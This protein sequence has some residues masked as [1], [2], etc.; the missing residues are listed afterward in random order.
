[1]KTPVEKIIEAVEKGYNENS[2]LW[3]EWK[4]T[5]IEAEQEL[6]MQAFLCG[7]DSEFHFNIPE[8]KSGKEFMQYYRARNDEI[9]KPT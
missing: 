8:I 9:T 2:T 1:M 7:D 4:E 5:M 6:I 3:K